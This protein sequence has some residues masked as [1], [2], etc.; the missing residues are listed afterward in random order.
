MTCSAPPRNF[1]QPR[2]RSLS[3]CGAA[4]S[5]CSERLRLLPWLRLW[6]G[7]SLR[8]AQALPTPGL[9]IGQPLFC[10]RGRIPLCEQRQERPTVIHFAAQSVYQNRIFILIFPLTDPVEQVVFGMSELQKISSYALTGSTRYAHGKRIVGLLTQNRKWLL[11]RMRCEQ[12]GR[13]ATRAV[14]QD[15]WC[16]CAENYT[17]YL[18][19]VVRETCYCHSSRA[20]RS[21]SRESR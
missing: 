1:K 15:L 13:T 12:Q 21:V 10:G 14:N 2:T 4:A 16:H 19:K 17:C 9:N 18:A 8:T 11:K 5:S 7:M 20:R 3:S 6:D